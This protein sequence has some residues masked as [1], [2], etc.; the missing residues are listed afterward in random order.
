MYSN[1]LVEKI[2]SNE[3]SEII[4]T[5]YTEFDAFIPSHLRESTKGSKG[6]FPA[7][8]RAEIEAMNEWVY[9]TINNGV[10]KTG[11]ATT[12]AAYEEHIYPIFKSLDRLEEHLGKPGHQP[13]LFGENITEA[14]I[15]L[16][17]T[18]AR[19]DVAYFTVFKCNLKMIRYEYPRL[20]KWLRQLYWDESEKT[21]GGAFKKST[22]FHTVSC[23][24]GG[25]G[26]RL[27]F[28]IVQSRVLEGLTSACCACGTGA[29]RSA[30]VRH[31]GSIVF[32]MIYY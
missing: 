29:G 31:S 23:C 1:T 27:T 32:R 24:C 19:F 15:R 21:N 7:H 18:I 8:L 30:S 25:V 2:V 14:D 3:S 13:Y 10:Y 11:F 6:L 4:R 5:F 16:Y 12:Q 20:H 28:A 26:A 22:V 9:D 17:P